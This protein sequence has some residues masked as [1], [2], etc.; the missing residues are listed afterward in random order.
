MSEYEKLMQ[1]IE[2]RR[3]FKAKKEQLRKETMAE[4]R[5]FRRKNEGLMRQLVG[6]GAKKEKVKDMS[7]GSESTM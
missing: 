6:T 5:D 1:K 3:K 4:I 7:L 2:N